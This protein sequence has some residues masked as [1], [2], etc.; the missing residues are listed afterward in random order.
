MRLKGY[1]FLLLAA[2]FLALPLTAN[3]QSLMGADGSTEA[4]PYVQVNHGPIAIWRGGDEVSITHSEDTEFLEGGGVACAGPTGAP[5]YTTDNQYWRLFDLTEFGITDDVTVTDVDMALRVTL[6][7]LDP[8]TTTLN[9]WAVDGEFTMANLTLIGSVDF[10]V[11]DEMSGD[12]FIANIPIDG[13]T[14]PG[15]STFA[16]EWNTPTG[17]MADTGLDADFDLRYGQNS[18]GETGPTYLSSTGCGITEPT[19]T[20]DIG[21]FDHLHWVVVINGVTGGVANEDAAVAQSVSLGQNYPNPVVG[22]TTVPFSLESAQQVRVSVIDA[23]GRE[24]LVAADEAFAAGEQTVELDLTNLPSGVY[25]Y[26][27]ATEG[28]TFSR[29]LVVMQ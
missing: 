19:P 8:Q 16:F 27:V 17:A 22:R 7:G 2:T 3:A 15:G 13:I 5:T 23:L 10:D 9:F 25:I 14:I 29:K 1:S 24:V 11:T 12:A 6:N 21:A 26:R 28:Q 20:G 4:G 18:L